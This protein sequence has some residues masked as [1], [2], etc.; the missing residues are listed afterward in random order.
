MDIINELI[1]S[2]MPTSVA[3]GYFDGVHRGH[4]AVIGEAVRTG[5]E[6]GLVPTVFTLL[7]SPRTVLRGE[8]S[9]NIITLDEKLSEFELLGA[10][11]VY[12]IDF[13]AI[14]DITAESFVSEVIGRCFNAKHI[15]CGFNYHFG[16]GA[17][18]SG[19]QLEQMC[20][21]SGITVLARP[22][23]TLG[24][25]PVSSTRIR[26][27]IIEG[28]IPAANEMLGRLYGFR[29]EVVHGRQLG[30]SWG[31]PTMN[32]IF[33]AELVKPRF[34][35][36]ASVVTV[37][38]QSFCGVTNIGIK[39]TVGSQGVLIETWMPD[40]SGR[41]LYGEKV[42]IRLLRFIRGERKFPD[43]DALKE[44]IKRNGEY[45]REIYRDYF[46]NNDL[47]FPVH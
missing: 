5:R 10:E 11:Q 34:G 42:D 44:E 23:I 1:P 29:L 35:V 18:G 45:S 19:A 46:E 3:L 6:N 38:G 36:Y 25:S 22:R 47:S 27:S 2:E 37:D 7:Q 15:A 20:E 39:P 12:L 24:G 33:P 16:A 30:R 8:K 31:T 43:T 26:A 13:T 41:E 28:D 32:Q 9:N 4:K 21:G 17:K 40:Y 14:K